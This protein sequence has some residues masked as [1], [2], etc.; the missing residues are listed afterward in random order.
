ML[1]KEEKPSLENDCYLEI[2]HAISDGLIPKA[3]CFMIKKKGL[4][5]VSFYSYVCNMWH[6]AFIYNF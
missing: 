6:R 5:W 4:F 1:D 3:S 2:V